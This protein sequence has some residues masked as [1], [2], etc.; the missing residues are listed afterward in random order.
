MKKREE[1]IAIGYLILRGMKKM[2]KSRAIT[3]ILIQFRKC[4]L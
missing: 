1:E 2:N 3:F 4:I